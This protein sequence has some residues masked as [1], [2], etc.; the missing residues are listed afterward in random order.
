MTLMQGHVSMPN[1]QEMQ[2]EAC[3]PLPSP[4]SRTTISTT[5][6]LYLPKYLLKCQP[7]RGSTDHPPQKLPCRVG[8]SPRSRRTLGYLAA[9]G[10]DNRRLERL[11]C[12]KGVRKCQSSYTTYV[13]LSLPSA[14]LLFLLCVCVCVCVYFPLL[15]TAPHLPAC[16]ISRGFPYPPDCNMFA[17]QSSVFAFRRR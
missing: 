2:L 1:R 12:R 8:A 15:S 10:L 4:S 9:D 11:A 13:L 6:I 16:Q 5:Y 7:G 14:F 3:T 17:R